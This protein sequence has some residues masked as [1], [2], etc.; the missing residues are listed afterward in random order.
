MPGLALM[1]GYGRSLSGSQWEVLR[2]NWGDP[3][4]PQL[5]LFPTPAS[6]DLK[7][8]LLLTKF[9]GKDESSARNRRSLSPVLPGSQ[10]PAPPPG[11]PRVPG[12]WAA[13]SPAGLAAN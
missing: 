6:L 2:W 8:Q 13:D 1:P 12:L 4:P 9:I 7:Q 10:G 11:E 3:S 5:L